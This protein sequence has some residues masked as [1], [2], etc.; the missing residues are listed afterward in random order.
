MKTVELLLCDDHQIFREGVRATFQAEKS[1]E[2]IAEA[3]NG[4]DCLEKLK[5]HLPD[6]VLL[7]INM[8]EM[9]GIEALQIIKKD[10][11]FIKVLALTQYDEKRFVK[12][13]MKFG[14]D[15]YILKNTSKREMLIAI[16]RVMKNGV[17]LADEAEA[18]VNNIKAEAE[19]DR[20][21][22]NL[23]KRERQV[24][25]MLCHELSTKQIADETGLS[26]HTIESHR[27]NIF[28]K[29]GVGNVAGVV[30]WAVNNDMD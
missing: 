16:N 17:Y 5:K 9:D 3:E 24:I 2:I 11:P 26:V 25:T 30:R 6:V 29:L 10:Y 21:F 13:M 18:T 12:Q 27:S 4:R 20:L 28:K 23:T 7:D 15:G 22:P 8:P 1:V 14:A 19:T